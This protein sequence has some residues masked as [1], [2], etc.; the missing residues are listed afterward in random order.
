MSKAGSVVLKLFPAKD[1]TGERF[2]IPGRFQRVTFFLPG[3]K[4]AFSVEED[5][6]NK[7]IGFIVSGAKRK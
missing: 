1:G 4:P 5:A 7:E 3:N 2:L 6:A